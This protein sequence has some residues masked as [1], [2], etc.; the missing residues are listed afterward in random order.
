MRRFGLVFDDASFSEALVF[1]D[2][3]VLWNLVE[4][5]PLLYF[6]GRVH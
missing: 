5:C 2:A 4:R 3:D 6:L 1:V